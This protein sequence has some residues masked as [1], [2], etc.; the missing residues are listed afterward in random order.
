MTEAAGPP[1]GIVPVHFAY[2]CEDCTTWT[3][4]GAGGLE[5]ELPDAAAGSGAAFEISPDGAGVVYR[6]SNDGRFMHFDLRRGRP[7]PVGPEGLPGD[8]ELLPF[9]EFSRDGKRLGITYGERAAKVRARRPR[10]RDRE[11]VRGQHRLHRQGLHGHA[12][13]Q[14]GHP[15]DRRL[16]RPE[17]GR[18]RRPVVGYLGPLPRQPRRDGAGRSGSRTRWHLRRPPHGRHGPGPRREDPPT[19]PV[20]LSEEPLPPG[21]DPRLGHPTQIILGLDNDD[22]VFGSV[23]YK[24]D[25]E[26]NTAS[27]LETFPHDKVAHLA[28]GG[29]VTDNGHTELAASAFK[30]L[31]VEGC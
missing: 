10:G 29:F 4:R 3:L 14:G 30:P 6:R 11:A 20:E 19:G 5:W 26:K 17:A 24:V 28:V 16:R 21:R 7:T 31:P 12:P 2:V 1:Q 25:L 13:G 23:V 22:S 15:H 27:K 8:D 18:V 9:L